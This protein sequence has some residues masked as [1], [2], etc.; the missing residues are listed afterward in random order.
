MPVTMTIKKKHSNQQPATPVAAKE[1]GPAYTPPSNQKKKQKKETLRERVEHTYWR[2]LL[3]KRIVFKIKD[4]PETSGVLHWVSTY[5][6]GIQKHGSETI[7]LY[8]KINVIYFAPEG[9]QDE[10]CAEQQRSAQAFRDG[11]FS[12][13]SAVI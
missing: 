9:T 10:V 3:G 4:E 7:A 12:D 2:A 5:S 11:V 8:N 1:K 6:M 13:N